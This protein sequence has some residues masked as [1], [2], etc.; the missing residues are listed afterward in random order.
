MYKSLV[1]GASEVFALGKVFQGTRFDPEEK[2]NVTV[3][4]PDHLEVLSNFK[5]NIQLRIQCSSIKGMCES[6]SVKFYGD[7]ATLHVDLLQQKMWLGK[8][9][10]TKLSEYPINSEDITNRE[11][12]KSFIDSILI[13]KPVTLTNFADGVKYMTFIDAVTASL[14]TKKMIALMPTHQRE[15]IC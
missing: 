11:V 10:E 7:E 15:M 2:F 8:R 5:D 1:R 14:T 13:K 9:F 6:S 4:I 12:E 3:N